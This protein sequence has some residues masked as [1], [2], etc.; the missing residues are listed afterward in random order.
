M[1]RPFFRTALASSM[2]LA[3]GWGSDLHPIQGRPG[4]AGADAGV[5]PPCSTAQEDADGD[6]YTKQDGDCDE[7]NSA[8]NPGALDLDNNGVDEDC[9]GR[10]DD[11][12]AACD[13]DLDAAGDAEL[14][15]KALG[16]CR[17]TSASASGASR[18]WGLLAA[19]FVYPDGTTASLPADE[20]MDC[21]DELGAPNPLSHG[22]L[23]AFGPNIGAR[24]GSRFLALSSGVARAGAHV[25]EGDGGESPSGGFMCTRSGVPEGFPASSYA[26]CGDE[27]LAPQGDAHDPNSAYDGMALE[28]EL[29][30]PTN[31]RGISFDF[32]FY[33]F[34]Y[35]HFV[36]STFNDVF[37]ALLY[38]RSPGLPASRNI[39]FDAQR[40]PIGV[41]NG[42]VE[43]CEPY[44]YVGIRN[45]QQ[46]TRSFTC[47]YGTAELAG[48]GFDSE[49]FGGPHAATGWLSTRASI[50]PGEDFVLRLAIWDAGDEWRDSTVL[51][52]NFRWEV[53]EGGAVTVRPTPR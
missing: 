16:I 14:A 27:L 47:G 26:T 21:Q 41:N 8:V 33:S 34:E 10:V 15:A 42:F 22:I 24:Q 6:G 37:A 19:R 18:S 35:P 44:D 7:C 17:T 13:D 53:V 28:L 25:L 49:V 38:S 23:R 4:S 9:S 36:C 40:N 45:G 46:F 50:E 3:C 12:L 32:D 43:V 5:E 29:R 48:T 52:D 31:A 2:L 51:L 11:E 39:A 1:F 30:A 20:A